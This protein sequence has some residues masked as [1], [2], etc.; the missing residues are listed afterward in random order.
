MLC[1]VLN[2]DGSEHKS[3][4]RAKFRKVLDSGRAKHQPWVGFEQEYTMFK[5]NVPLGWP[6]H[7]CPA[8]QGPYY[9]GVGSEQIFSRKLAIEHAEFCI[10]ANLIFYGMNAEV[11]PGQWE[12]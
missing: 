3:N 9:C 5:H 8:L 6:E 4:S 12:F 11:M 10:E 2:P 7:G 1:E